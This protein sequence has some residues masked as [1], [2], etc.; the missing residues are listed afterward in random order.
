MS[1]DR[2]KRIL[3]ASQK[4]AK[5]S[6]S[7][8]SSED[9]NARVAYDKMGK[10]PLMHQHHM[11]K[12]RIE[13]LKSDLPHLNGY[14]WYSWAKDFFESRHKITLLCAAN[15]I[16]KSSTQIR[17]CIEWAGNPK[18][19]PDLWD[20]QPKIFWYFYPS[21]LVA[22]VE[23]EKKWVPE[24]MPR[25]AMKDHPTYGWDV[26]YDSG[27]LVAIHFRSGV[28]V[29]FKTYGQKA[30]NLQTA[31]VHAIF[32]DEEMPEM[33]VDELLAR[34]RRTGGYFHQVF[35]A[36]LG[37]A[38]WYRAMECIGTED[39]AFKTAWKRTVSMY[40]CQFYEDGSPSPWT[41]DRIAE[42]EAQCTTRR[43]SLKRIHGR[44]VKDEGLRY[45]SF[46]PER[47]IKESQPVP[48]N[49]KLYAG[50]DIGSG[51]SKHRS[52]GAIIFVATNPEFTE[53]RVVRSWR[54]DNVETSSSDILCKYRE[55]LGKS[56]I[57]QACY[58]HSSKEFGIIA[59][60]SGAGFNPADKGKTS[61]EATTNTLFK[62]GALTIDSGVYDNQK[63]ITELMSVPGGPV[64]NRSYKDD[65]TDALKYCL[66]QI[67][68][69]FAKISPGSGFND[70]DEER[71]EIPQAEW[72]NQEYLAWEI[73]Q[74]RGE[75]T[76]EGD[77]QDCDAEF[78]AEIDEWNE[79]YG[80]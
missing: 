68:W 64:K 5:T 17:K 1:N 10:D 23:F 3:N 56:P 77:V 70:E 59:Q 39:E 78:R 75:A 22:Q 36:T 24:F 12:K 48:G 73:R 28:S 26:E 37:L 65:L 40:E 35:T 46:D 14:K 61:G 72:T 50:V 60:R 32:A 47:N 79:A 71:D 8:Q 57:T 18:L 52:S 49:W 45:E 76:T 38:L 42:A 6:V 11:V 74:R 27:T 58:D 63:L 29:Y 55:L 20:S 69:N 43:E 7:K 67:P 41:P 80:T 19:W 13:E 66:A 44:F 54:G 2:R 34:L 31:T 4:D 62:A 30:I 25:G 33:Y 9:S 53:G 21:E 15:Q 51:G 16:S